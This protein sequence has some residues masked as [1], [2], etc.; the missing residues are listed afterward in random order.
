MTTAIEIAE[1]LL[2]EPIAELWKEDSSLKKSFVE[3]ITILDGIIDKYVTEINQNK[4]YE[5][6]DYDRTMDIIHNFFRKVR[7]YLDPTTLNKGDYNIYDVKEITSFIAFKYLI[8]DYRKAITPIKAYDY[9]N[10][11][12]EYYNHPY[13][14]ICDCRDCGRPVILTYGEVKSFKNL[15]FRATRKGKQFKWPTRCKICMRIKKHKKSIK[16]PNYSEEIKLLFKAD[17]RDLE[18][19]RDKYILFKQLQDVAK[20][21]NKDTPSVFSFD[22]NNSSVSSKKYKKLVDSYIDQIKN[23]EV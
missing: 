12:T 14:K 18:E 17:I 4:D 1:K 2:I 6:S 23:G 22:V 11:P 13:S 5:I 9:Y 19:R 7:I 10:D 20:E 16:N 8:H 21:Y 3:R 15:I